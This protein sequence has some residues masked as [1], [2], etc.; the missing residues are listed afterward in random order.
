[1]EHGAV[2]KLVRTVAS[3][4]LVVGLAAGVASLEVLA[5]SPATAAP[6]GQSGA[7]DDPGSGQNNGGDNGQKPPSDGGGLLGGVTGGLLG[8]KP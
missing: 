2:R 4:S 8:G 3:A 6:S 1:M 5:A 7:F